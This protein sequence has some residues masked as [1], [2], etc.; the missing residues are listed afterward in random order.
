MR[1]AEQ[2][3]ALAK[4]ATSQGNWLGLA[5]WPP[6]IFW[7]PSVFSSPQI[8]ENCR[9]FFTLFCGPW[10]HF[11]SHCGLSIVLSL[12]PLGYMV[13]KKFQTVKLFCS[14]LVDKIAGPL[15]ESVLVQLLRQFF[16]TQIIFWRKEIAIFKAISQR[17]LWSSLI[18]SNCLD[19][20]YHSIGTWRFCNRDFKT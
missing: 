14:F 10:R 3:Q 12:R 5:S 11:H 6:T 2:N 20:T 4:S 13:K 7:E 18:W 9:A 19:A 17:T 1:E 8:S 16:P 15:L